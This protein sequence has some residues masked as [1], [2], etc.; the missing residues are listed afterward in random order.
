MV[1]SGYLIQ[2]FQVGNGLKTREV[3]FLIVFWKYLVAG[4]SQVPQFL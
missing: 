3:E 1:T 4:D 2:P